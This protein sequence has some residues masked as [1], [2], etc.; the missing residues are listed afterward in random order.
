MARKF[1]FSDSFFDDFIDIFTLSP[2]LKVYNSNE[3]E[4]RIKE[5]V[6]ARRIAEKEEYIKRLELQRDI[7]AKGYDNRI[8]AVKDEIAQLKKKL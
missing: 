1:Y 5:G 8:A 4:L 3:Y 6:V 2:D 7:E